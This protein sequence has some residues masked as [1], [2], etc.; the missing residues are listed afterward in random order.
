MRHAGIP[1]MPLKMAKTVGIL[2]LVEHG[3]LD[4]AYEGFKE[5][6]AEGGYKRRRKP[7]F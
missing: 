4:A 6:L 2:Q 7:Y 1:T 3:S 5:G